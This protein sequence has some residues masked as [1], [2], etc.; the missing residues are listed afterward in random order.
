MIIDMNAYIGKWPFWPVRASSA[1]EVAGDLDGWRIDAAA[2]CSTRCIFVNC[3]DGNRETAMAAEQQ[4]GQFFPFA[5]L[6]PGDAFPSEKFYGVR[7]YPQHHSYHPL[8]EPE[9]DRIIS[10]AME[11]KWPVLLP[12]RLIMNW[13]MPM[14]ELGVINALV[15]RHPQATWILAGINY[16]HELQLAV[17]LMKRFETVH[18]E[19]SCI[20]GYDAIAKTVDQCGSRQL[21]FGSGAPVQHGGAGVA[22]IAHAKISDAARESI[23]HVNAERLLGLSNG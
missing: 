6:G 21:L 16:L 2:I 10:G 4:P 1:S 5:S 11:R 9:T 12:L 13:G 19:T 15:E 7:L 3:A 17:H 20:M 14:Q 18:V 8:F 23:I 22:K